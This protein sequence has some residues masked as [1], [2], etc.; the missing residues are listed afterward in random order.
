MPVVQNKG[1]GKEESVSTLKD[2]AFHNGVQVF[3]QLF[4]YQLLKK[5]QAA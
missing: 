2:L 4:Y 3:D 5:G 1:T